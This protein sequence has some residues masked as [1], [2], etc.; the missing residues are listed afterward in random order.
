MWVRYRVNRR[1]VWSHHPENN[2]I[3]NDDIINLILDME[4]LTTDN[5]YNKYFN[6][7]DAEILF[8]SEGGEL[9]N[10]SETKI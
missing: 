4:L 7:R 2:G 8:H 1:I 10:Y 5:F 6:R 3:T 9:W